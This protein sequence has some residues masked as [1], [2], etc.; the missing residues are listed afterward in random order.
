MYHRI[1]YC[2]DLD[3]VFLHIFGHLH[4]VEVYPCLFVPRPAKMISSQ[5]ICPDPQKQANCGVLRGPIICE[6]WHVDRNLFP[7]CDSLGTPQYPDRGFQPVRDCRAFPIQD[8]AY[9][10]W[11]RVR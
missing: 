7:A 9:Y 1:P 3:L 6:S 8:G 10:T 5:D 2:V 11:Y 4:H